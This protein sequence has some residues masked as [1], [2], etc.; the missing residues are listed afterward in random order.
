MLTLTIH[1]RDLADR[2]AAHIRRRLDDEDAGLVCRGLG[3]LALAAAAIGAWVGVTGWLL[4]ALA[5][6]AGRLDVVAA[7]AA[8]VALTLAC[9]AALAALL[10]PIP[11]RR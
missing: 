10:W 1:P 7:V 3:A 9:M 5:P 2:L 6:I 11:V 4:A 8:W